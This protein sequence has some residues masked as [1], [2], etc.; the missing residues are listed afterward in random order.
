[1]L[2][3]PIYSPQFGFLAFRIP[4]F[5][6]LA[7]KTGLSRKGPSEMSVMDEQTQQILTKQSIN[8]CPKHPVS[9]TEYD[10]DLAII[11]CLYLPMYYP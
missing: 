5:D 7:I 8:A 10:Y 9:I 6:W 2:N 1:M 4:I 3:T 11:P